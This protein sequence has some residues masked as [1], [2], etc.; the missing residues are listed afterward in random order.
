MHAKN[1]TAA[2]V[3]PNEHLGVSVSKAREA[4]DEAKKQH[5]SSVFIIMAQLNGTLKASLLDEIRQVMDTTESA[6]DESHLLVSV[7]DIGLMRFYANEYIGEFCRVPK[8]IAEL[9][10]LPPSY[11]ELESDEVDRVISCLMR[12]PPIQFRYASDLPMTW[13][14]HVNNTHGWM[15]ISDLWEQSKS[16]YKKAKEKSLVIATFFRFLTT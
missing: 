6:Y 7:S 15:W 13:E 10:S 8:C 9:C 3:V 11:E 4:L 16:D 12:D 5:N 2:I 1:T 14:D